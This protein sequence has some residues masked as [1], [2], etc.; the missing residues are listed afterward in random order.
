MIKLIPVFI[1]IILGCS[2]EDMKSSNES[3]VDSENMLFMMVQHQKS[4]ELS[5]QVNVNVLK[6]VKLF[7]DNEKLQKLYWDFYKKTI[8]L[9]NTAMKA[10][11]IMK[12]IQFII[13][14]KMTEHNFKRK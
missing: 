10:R 8:E 11:I 13:D 2:S 6:K 7:D 5:N 9:H 4:I 14:S 3:A 1:F 12:K